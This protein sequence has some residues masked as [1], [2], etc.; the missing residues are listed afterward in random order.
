[1][2]IIRI[3]N[4][5]FL[6]NQF[7]LSNVYQLLLLPPLKLYIEKKGTSKK[8]YA[9]NSI[10]IVSAKREIIAHKHTEQTENLYTLIETLHTHTPSNKTHYKIRQAKLNKRPSAV[11]DNHYSGCRTVS[12]C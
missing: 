8:Y 3:K 10:K 12:N 11:N 2:T 4:L 1:M 5:D 6:I 7:N 9:E